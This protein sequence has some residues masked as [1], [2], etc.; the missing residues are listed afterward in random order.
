MCRRVQAQRVS[1]PATSPLSPPGEARP[2]RNTC[3]MEM[4]GCTKMGPC[5]VW[6]EGG[7]LRWQV[8]EGSCEGRTAGTPLCQADGDPCKHWRRPPGRLGRAWGWAPRLRPRGLEGVV[9]QGRLSL[10]ARPR[11][12]GTR[13]ALHTHL[14]VSEAGSSQG[15]MSTEQAPGPK[16]PRPERT[17]TA[18]R[19]KPRRNCPFQGAARGAAS[20]WQ[21][22]CHL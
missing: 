5:G 20:K 15:T 4:C 2:A 21:A 19:E 8:Q 17:F 13:E 10:R 7:S 18:E 16:K 9:A 1:V 12:Q 6:L 14:A 3:I 11:L 22:T